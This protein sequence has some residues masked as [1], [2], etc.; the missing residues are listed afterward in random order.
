[1]EIIVRTIDDVTVADITGDIDGKTAPEAQA[2]IL[3]LL[4]PGCKVI[5]NMSG[6]E[7]MSSAGLRMMLS[8]HRETASNKGHLVLVGLSEDIQDTMSATGF[9]NF[10]TI[11]DT[12]ESG[13][14]SLK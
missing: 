1:M 10:F 4:Q 8:M 7:Y 11:Q 2:A 14:D 9:L 13:L 3:P 12:V 5:V 6:V